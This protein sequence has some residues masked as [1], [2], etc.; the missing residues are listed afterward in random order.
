MPSSIPYDPSL[1]LANIVGN[2][3]LK[4]V[5]Q[6]S[7][8]QAPV[9][10]CQE[11]L[12][13]LLATKRSMQ[14]T[15]SELSNIGV[16]TS[17]IKKSI[18]ALDH[19][20]EAAAADYIEEKMEA[21]E[22]IQPLRAT[23]RSVHVEM[24]TPVDYVKTQI[25]SMPLASDSIS[26]DV[27]YFANDSNSEQASSLASSVSSYIS[28]AASVLG[29]DKAAQMSR[30]AASQVSDQ[31][32]KHSIAGTLVISVSCTHKNAA[33]L[34]PL[35]L[36]VDKGIKVWNHLFKDDPIIPTS[37]S[38][39]LQT[40]QRG[41]SGK[42]DGNRFSI[43]SGMTFGS[44]FV[45]MVHILNTSS[46]AVGER[47]DTK[48]STLQAQFKE[49]LVDAGWL[50]HWSGGFGVNE[51]MASSVKS[52]LSSQNIDSHATM[53]CMGVIP[54][55]VASEVQLGVDKFATFD[56]KSSLEAL[57]AIQNA[58]VADQD[59]VKQ[60][61]DAARTG[62]QLL[63]MKNS[64]MKAALSALAEIDDGKNKVIDVNSM[65]T[66]L[67]DY[68]KKAAEGTSGVPINYYLKEIDKSM[69]AEMWVAKYYPG[70]YLSISYDDASPSGP[71]GGAS[72]GG[73]SEAP[74]SNQEANS[75]EESY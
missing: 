20:I 10:A 42:E 43:I 52:L 31:V 15:C 54:S 69:L 35:V 5:Q 66:A 65:M 61:A 71:A 70:K 6:I 8:L 41:A 53:I 38:N 57:S 32:S 51:S 59:T 58:S 9:D 60:A 14:M 11:Q 72:A 74:A 44:S 46:T 68:L 1:V 64:E 18:K 36:N 56:P 19:K 26:M 47:A 7:A 17:K 63:S 34:A 13:S 50:A 28:G 2:D 67:E 3:A 23:I 48:L 21:E 37:T 39:M 75:N 25:K 27:Q 29:N 49:Q 12:N 30:A 62:A 4:L 16:E 45:G 22:K 55:I 40:A 24:E 73:S 33:V